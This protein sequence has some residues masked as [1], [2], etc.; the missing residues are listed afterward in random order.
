M[1][2]TRPSCQGAPFLWTEASSDVILQLAWSFLLAAVLRLGYRAWLGSRSVF[3][4]DY[5][6]GDQ[7]EHGL[8]WASSSATR[9][10]PSSPC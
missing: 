2:S 7:V 9:R 1:I 8:V 3:S 10:G 5:Y 4:H 6:L